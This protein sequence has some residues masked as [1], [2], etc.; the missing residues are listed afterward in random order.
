MRAICLNLSCPAVSQTY[1]RTFSISFYDESPFEEPS[2]CKVFT[3]KSQA[4]VGA[5]PLVSTNMLS[6][7]RW[8]IDVLPTI[9]SPIRITLY[10][11]AAMV[12][13]LTLDD[14]FL[15]IFK[16]LKY[17]QIITDCF[18]N[19]YYRFLLFRAY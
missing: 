18:I 15:F 16:L 8:I 9:E 11:F 14:D 3:L 1:K 5:V 10:Y 4:R 7:N 12:P 13:F 19:K 6:M 17:L 2:T